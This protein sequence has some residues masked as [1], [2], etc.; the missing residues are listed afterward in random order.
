MYYDPGWIMENSMIAIRLKDTDESL[1]FV[2]I[3]KRNS[4]YS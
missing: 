3:V 2:Q 1:N 4:L